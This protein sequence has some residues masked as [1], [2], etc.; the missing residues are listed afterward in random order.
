MTLQIYAGLTSQTVRFFVQDTSSTSGAGLTGLTSAT[1]G[2]TAYYSKGGTGSATAITLASQTATGAWTSGGFCAVDGTN[3][4]GVY[5]LDIPNAALDSEVETIV[6]LRGAASMAPVCLRVT[7]RVFASDGVKWGGAAVTGMPMPTYTQPTGFLAATFPSVIPTAAAI[8]DAVWDEIL[9]G[10][11]HNIQNSAGKRLRTIASQVVHTGT[12]Q[13]PGTGSNQIQLDTGASATDGIYDP[14][15]LYIESGT[16]A[17]QSRLITQ[18]VGSTRTATVDRDWRVAPAADSV[19]VIQATIGFNSTNEGL[20][21][22]GTSTTIV[23]NTSANSIDDCYNGQLVFLKSGTGQD[24]VAIVEDYTGSTRTALIRTRRTNGQWATVP[25][26]TTGYMMVPNLTWTI[27]EIQAGLAT[28]AAQT[29][30]QSDLDDIQSRLPAALVA[31]RMDAS[32]GAMQADTVTSAAL[33][34]S[35]V[36]EIQSGLATSAAQT[37]AQSDLDDIQSRLP[38]ALVA[39]RMDASV[40]VMQADTVTSAALAASAVT[41]IQSGLATSAAQTT[42]QSE[43]DDI[44]SRLPAALVAG[45]MDASVGAMQADTVTSA[46]LAASAVTE[47]QAGLSTLT[48][49]QVKAQ[50]IEAL[51]VDILAEISTIPGASSTLTDRIGLL[52]ALAR[53]KLTQTSSL[54]TVFADNGS[55]TIGT[56]TVADNGTTFTRNKLS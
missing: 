10:A 40:G 48:D 53:N 47:I 36:T 51:S 16:G 55:T 52:F 43:L 22:G 46:A 13:G 42:A 32:V 21:Q 56:A 49:V 27:D 8:A 3:M 24:Q 17:E 2:L 9:T 6:M 37:T 35:A 25:D 4:P 12:A 41:E 34:A 30:A 29:T 15:M 39:G 23:L 33:E 1:S 28:A 26:S 20:A 7:G 44:Q 14:A 45:R 5:R 50:I 31:G 18:Y 19:F 11:T 38:A 54:Q